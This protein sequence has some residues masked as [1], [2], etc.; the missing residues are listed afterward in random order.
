M[1]VRAM[2]GTF[3]EIPDDKTEEYK[4]PP[5]EVK[6]KLGATCGTALPNAPMGFQNVNIPSAGGSPQVAINIFTHETP[7][8]GAQGQPMGGP[9]AQQEGK[10]AAAAPC[11]SLHCYIPCYSTCYSC[12]C[13]S[14]CYSCYCYC[15]SCYVQPV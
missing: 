4:I 5:A 2:D 9:V 10:E 15:Y 6:E 13:Y 7:P 1:I 12:Y 3:Y 8:M 14:T 11:Y